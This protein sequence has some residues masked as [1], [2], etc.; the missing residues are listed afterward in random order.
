[1]SEYTRFVH[2]F[3]ALINA[4][5][6]KGTIAGRQ[7]I[8][9]SAVG[10]F[11][12]AETHGGAWWSFAKTAETAD[13]PRGMEMVKNSGWKTCRRPMRERNS[14]RNRIAVHQISS[15]SV[16]CF[17]NNFMS[18]LRHRWKNH[19]CSFR[20]QNCFHTFLRELFVS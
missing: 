3:F 11:L 1:M 18:R 19:N 14:G 17:S 2:N 4:I 15:N 6:V 10:E 16:F 5:R 7:I 9:R 13:I 8:N 12:R 20:C